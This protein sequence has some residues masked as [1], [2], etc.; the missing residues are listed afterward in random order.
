[1]MVNTVNIDAA[2]S[3][4]TT[5]VYGYTRNPMYVGIDL[6]FDGLGGLSVNS[7]GASRTNGICTLHHTV[8]DRAGGTGA[9]PHLRARLRRLP[10]PGPTLAVTRA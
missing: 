5:G 1:M 8:P 10:R 4:V 3:L 6:S 9:W 2:S 7:A